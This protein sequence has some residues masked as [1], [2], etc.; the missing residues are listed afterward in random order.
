MN[1]LNRRATVWSAVKATGGWAGKR[2]LAALACAL[3][4][5]LGSRAVA[6]ISVSASDDLDRVR[7]GE[8]FE[9]VVVVHGD[10][11]YRVNDPDVGKR[12]GD[13]VVV[14]SER[15]EK[16][17]G[18]V[19][20]EFRYTLAG[21]KLDR[22]TIASI[23]IAYVDP[24]GRAGKLATDPL[25]VTIVGTAPEGEK[26]IKDIRGM[27]EIEPRMA[28]WLK[29]L[30][31][32]GVVALAAAIVLWQ[33]RKRR[34]AALEEPREK[35][36]LPSAVAL[37]ALQRLFK[38]DLLFQKRYKEF[39][40]ALSD[41][42]RQFLLGRL[43]FSADDMTTTEIEFAMRDD[44]ISKQFTTATLEILRFSDM[45]KF[46]KLIPSDLENDEIIK[47]ARNAIESGLEPVFN[48]ET[49][50]FP[51]AASPSSNKEKSGGVSVVD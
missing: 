40:F 17:D 15:R 35:A 24:A 23:E 14:K 33:I 13:F 20:L 38:S 22:A 2:R 37:A 21:F 46:A 47:K 7:L 34:T 3:F 31:C 8:Q 41:I 43:R 49:E 25:G 51:Q 27:I 32:L 6:N 28:L 26:E 39:Y 30:I 5:L 18:K 4:L 42:I 10:E 12:L 16:E 36:P 50:P 19:P 48:T 9:L 1:N 11:G 29:I 44:P 45:V